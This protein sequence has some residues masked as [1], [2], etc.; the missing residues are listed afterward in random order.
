M[1]AYGGIMKR[2]YDLTLNEET[3]EKLK[4]MLEPS[5]QSLSSLVASMIDEYVEKMEEFKAGAHI[6]DDVHNLSISD[7]GRMFMSI[8]TKMAE[9]KKKP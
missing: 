1:K 4:K 5:G 8:M 7:L 2:R 6:P 9:N 3:T